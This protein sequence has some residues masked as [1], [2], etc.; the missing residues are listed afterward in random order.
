MQNYF[1]ISPSDLYQ[2]LILH[3]E[4][5]Y[6][7]IW[8]DFPEKLSLDNYLI[9]TFG[10]IY[11]KK[12]NFV[13]FGGRGEK[14][15]LMVYLK[16][17]SGSTKYTIHKLMASTF[18]PGHMGYVYHKDKCPWNNHVMNLRVNISQYELTKDFIQRWG[19][20]DIE[21]LKKLGKCRINPSL[22][23]VKQ[24][25]FTPQNISLPG[26]ERWKEIT[27]NGVRIEVSS[28]GRI[29]FFTPKNEP[30]ICVPFPYSRYMCVSLP[31]IPIVDINTLMEL[32]FEI[33]IEDP[34]GRKRK[35]IF[36]LDKNGT[37]I[38]EYTSVEK[39]SIKTDHSKRQRKT[40][41]GNR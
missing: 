18:F 5:I 15:Y 11:N 29:K 14:G 40:L 41:R 2:F 17:Y 31:K 8:C 35:S 38:K 13:Y 16:K 34:K 39:E 9:S 27:Y 33:K 25:H 24:P 21:D 4:L 3:E 22:G 28:K 10:R 37:L 12:D 1:D 20:K 19:N 30:R 7:E 23:G 6:K 32:A 36:C 26:F